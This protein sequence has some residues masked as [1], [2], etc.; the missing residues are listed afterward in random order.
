[1]EVADGFFTRLR[2]LLGRE[3]LGR[4]EGLLIVPSRGVHMFGM[5]FSL[6]ILL[7]DRERK[8]AASY[9]ALAPG[10]ATGMHRGVRYALELP[11][12]VIDA[13]GTGEGDSID[14]DETLK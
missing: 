9:R 14:W 3:G 2:G 6:D 1:V 11:V 12:G 7:L 5:R 8:V 10:K 4:G 13:S